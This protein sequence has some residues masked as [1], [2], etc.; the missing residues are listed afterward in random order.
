MWNKKQKIIEGLWKK[1]IRLII[2]KI[3]IVL[4]KFLTIVNVQLSLAKKKLDIDTAIFD[5]LAI[6]ILMRDF[7]QFLLL[8]RKLF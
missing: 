2:N 4:L 6:V 1:Q 3:S 8:I 7:Y 5:R